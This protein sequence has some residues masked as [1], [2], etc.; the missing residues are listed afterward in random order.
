[1]HKL[2]NYSGDSFTDCQ[3]FDQ[4]VGNCFGRSIG[5]LFSSLSHSCIDGATIEK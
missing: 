5:N 1:M 2:L 4:E 3:R